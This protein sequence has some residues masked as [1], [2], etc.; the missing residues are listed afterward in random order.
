M[1]I[2]IRR[3]WGEGMAVMSF[4][5]LMF[6]TSYYAMALWEY[7]YCRRAVCF[8]IYGKLLRRVVVDR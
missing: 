8:S 6:E 7:Y 1:W 2:G 4:C 5:G 3:P